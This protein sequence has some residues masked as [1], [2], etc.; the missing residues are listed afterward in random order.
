MSHGLSLALNIVE[1]IGWQSA[2]MCPTVLISYECAYHMAEMLFLCT[3]DC[4]E[5]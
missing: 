2:D 5:L 1:L 4:I 3:S